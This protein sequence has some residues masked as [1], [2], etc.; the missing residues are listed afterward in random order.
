MNAILTK[1]LLDKYPEIFP[2][3]FGFEH[4]D[5]WYWLIDKLCE[6][7]QFEIDHNNM[8][9]VKAVQVKQKF[10]GLRFYYDQ[11]EN[12]QP[13]GRYEPDERATGAVRLA[14]R[15]SASICE[16]CGVIGAKRHEI[17]CWMTTICNRC[18][19]ARSLPSP[20]EMEDL[21][22]EIVESVN[23]HFWSLVGE[24]DTEYEQLELFKKGK[25]K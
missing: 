3:D 24:D 14:E 5:G 19:A 15:M 9:Q 23:K 2:S 4:K 13:T 22:P 12:E 6:Y 18:L 20:N 25:P 17:N 1:K 21:D 16:H 11:I 8:N 10:S 7:L